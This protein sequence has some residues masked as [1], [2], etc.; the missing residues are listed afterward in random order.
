MDKKFGKCEAKGHW[1]GVG[2]KYERGTGGLD[3]EEEE[4]DEI[5]ARDL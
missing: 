3:D 5:T 1:S 2:I 4:P